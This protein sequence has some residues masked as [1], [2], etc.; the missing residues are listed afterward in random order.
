MEIK[1]CKCACGNISFKGQFILQVFHLCVDANG[2]QFLKTLF[3]LQSQSIEMQYTKNIKKCFYKKIQSDIL[4]L[5]CGTIFRTLI[6]DS[7]IY[8]EKIQRANLSIQKI[9]QYQIN[10]HKQYYYMNNKI[11]NIAFATVLQPIKQIKTQKEEKNLENDLIT[12]K[13][14]DENDT[15]F[16]LMFSNKFEPFIGSYKYQIIDKP[17]DEC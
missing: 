9:C 3:L 1:N 12:Q 14:F 2:L 11:S 13:L 17:V 15:D 4:C 16:D 8:I 7:K 5:F 6:C 10:M